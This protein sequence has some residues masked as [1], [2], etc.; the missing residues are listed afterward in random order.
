MPVWQLLS[1]LGPQK[2]TEG[3]QV[4]FAESDQATYSLDEAVPKIGPCRRT[5]SRC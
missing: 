4:G 2:Q 3:M 5:P 1:G